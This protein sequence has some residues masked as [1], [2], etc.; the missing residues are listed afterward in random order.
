MIRPGRCKLPLIRDHVNKLTRE[1]VFVAG[2][3]QV[4]DQPV[5]SR[6]FGH[7]RRRKTPV[8]EAGLQRQLRLGAVGANEFQSQ[9]GRRVGRQGGH[10]E[11]HGFAD[12]NRPD[13]EPDP[14]FTGL[15]LNAVGR[16]PADGVVP[17]LPV[18]AVA[19]CRRAEPALERG[20][21]ARRGVG[22]ERHRA[23]PTDL[24]YREHH[25]RAVLV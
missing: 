19:I 7:K 14:D 10:R 23:T 2:L 24:L 16:Q 12:V 18:V 21:P 25:Q 1:H 8:T 22:G 9:L 4:R 20:T 11:R 15:A 6:L 17:K 5:R 3:G 13:G